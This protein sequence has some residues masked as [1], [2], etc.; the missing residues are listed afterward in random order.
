[1]KK[2]FEV[3]VFFLLFSF[4][5]V[6]E[7]FGQYPAPVNGDYRSCNNGN[8]NIVANWEKF[9]STENKWNPSTEIPSTTYLTKTVTIQPGHTINASG[10]IS[11]PS[12]TAKIIVAENATL[13][14]NG[15]YIRGG[16][17]STKFNYMVIDGNLSS[18]N[19]VNVNY[20]DI[21]VN[22]VLTTSYSGGWFSQAPITAN[23]FGTV[24]FNGTNQ[25]IPPSQYSKVIVSGT[26]QKLINGQPTIKDMMTVENNTSIL[27]TETGTLIIE[28]VMNLY[29]PVVA[30]AGSSIDV[31]DLNL[32]IPDGLELQTEGLTSASMI[33]NGSLNSDPAA[34]GNIR[35]LLSVPGTSWHYISVPFSTVSKDVFSAEGVRNV[36]LYDES[37]ITTNTDNGWVNYEG[38]HYN[39]MTTPAAWQLVQSK[40]WNNLIAGRGYNY[41]SADDKSFYI[42][43]PVDNT[44][45]KVNLLF[46]SGGIG[47]PT[48][49]GY[50]LIG[51][52]F[53]S[54]ID[55]DLVTSDPINTDAEGWS[56]VEQAIYFRYNGS[57]ITYIGGVTI[58]N[59]YNELGNLVPPYQGF[60]IKSNINNFDLTIPLSARMHTPNLRYKGVILV[61][62]IRLELTNS[63][64]TDQ[65]AIR[66]DEKA[67]LDYDNSFD[68]RKLFSDAAVPSISSTLGGMNYS[69]N[70]IPYP[71]HSVTVPLT[72]NA[73]STGNYSIRAMEIQGLDNYR[74]TLK[75]NLLN[76][77]TNLSDISTYSFSS[78]TGKY[79][80]RFVLTVENITTA[81]PETKAQNIAFKIYGSSDALNIQLLNDSW[82]GIKSNLKIYDLTGRPVLSLSNVDFSSG[83]VKQIP[84]SA[85]KGAYIVEITG[86]YRRYVGKFISK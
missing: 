31:Y 34:T 13:N 17:T 25:Q 2:V 57:L 45:V 47:N 28:G 70:G 37:Y 54:G 81:I 73:P 67:T 53:F 55:W 38:Y 16:S 1:M 56:S 40:Q 26:G 44:D 62:L 49:Q 18:S 35:S 23:I 29:G 11:S 42:T 75:D 83:I 30:N 8:W 59:T 15:Y 84:F 27:I 65:T 10:S 24:V 21:G 39:V 46:G 3:S 79:S 72:I 71:E 52:P 50:N 77:S 5:L 63:V 85:Q 78:N 66:F 80:D 69:I 12:S 68:A 6:A 43:G 76:T 32:Y 82:S 14:M 20:L 4:I 41:Y 22:G 74:I 36:S 33:L 19:Y 7:S 48:A 86:D 51:N 61:P 60:F 9:N 64:K 58:P